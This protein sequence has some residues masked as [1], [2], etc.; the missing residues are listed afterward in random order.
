[1]NDTTARK[2]KTFKFTVVFYQID[3]YLFLWPL[4]RSL[5]LP[6]NPPPSLEPWMYSKKGL[7][8]GCTGYIYLPNLIGW[9]Y[10][11]NKRN[12]YLERII[13][14]INTNSVCTHS[15][16]CSTFSVR[17]RTAKTRSLSAFLGAKVRIY[18]IRAFLWRKSTDLDVNMMKWMHR[19]TMGQLRCL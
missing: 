13:Q 5:L 3:F 8:L 10:G 15:L 19:H 6:F 7:A 12:M 1:M 2:S 4:P 18:Y 9:W 17:L 16:T 11:S 14:S